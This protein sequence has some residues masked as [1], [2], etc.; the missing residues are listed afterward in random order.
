[1]NRRLLLQLAAALCLTFASILAIAVAVRADAG[2]IEVREAFARAS[3]GQATAGAVYLR[4][5]NHASSPDRLMAAS[6]PV[7]AR[8]DLHMTVHEGNVARMR[9]LET[10]EIPA[11]ETVAFEPGG[12]HVMLSGLHAPLREGDRFDLTLEFEAAGTIT[13]EVPVRS[14]AAEADTGDHGDGHGGH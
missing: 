11:G 7:A 10:V 6:T 12:A 4:I 2:G 9:R 8:T 13:V 1:M 14:V 3:I 5:V